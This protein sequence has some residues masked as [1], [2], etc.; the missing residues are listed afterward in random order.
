MRLKLMVVVVAAM[1]ALGVSAAQAAIQTNTYTE[2]KVDYEDSTVFGSPSFSFSSGGGLR[3]FGWDVPATVQ[4]YSTGVGASNSFVL[5]NFTITANPGWT[6]SGPFTSFLGNIVFN[7]VGPGATTSM[8]AGATLSFDGGGPG[9]I[10]PVAVGKTVSFAGP[11]VSS[12]YYSTTLSLAHG[13]FT[14]LSLT[15]G[16]LT[17][18]AGSPIFASIQAQP[19]NNLSFS[20]IATP[21]PEPET[22]ALW[23]AG[24]L[25]VV[26]IARRRSQR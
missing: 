8:T 9:A 10:P 3:G 1:A 22:A 25:A 14:T 5:P 19:Q 12:G 20:V 13:A 24:L 18:N 2:F 7:E 11:G 21:V 15:A 26:S 16:T 6:L 17:L 23:L 4:A